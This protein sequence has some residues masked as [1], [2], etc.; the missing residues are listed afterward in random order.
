MDYKNDLFWILS[1]RKWKKRKLSGVVS[2]NSPAENH[3]TL[4]FVAGNS[5]NSLIVEYEIVV[6]V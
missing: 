6:S 1:P 3:A 5:R 2:I 4:K